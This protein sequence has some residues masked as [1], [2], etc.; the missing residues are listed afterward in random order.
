MGRPGKYFNRALVDPMKQPTQTQRLCAHVEWTNHANGHGVWKKC[1]ECKLRLEY[2][3]K[4]SGVVARYANFSGVCTVMNT[5]GHS[6]RAQK[7]VDDE[8]HVLII[9]DSGCKRSV[10]GPAWHAAMESACAKAGLKPI[11]KHIN[12]TFLFGD[13]D[14]V[15]AT[16]AVEYPVGIYELH[17]SLDVALVDRPCPGLMS[18]KAMGEL[19]CVMD[20]EQDTLK[21]KAHDGLKTMPINNSATGHPVVRLTD[22]GPGVHEAFPRKF[23]QKKATATSGKKK[24]TATS[25]KEIAEVNLSPKAE[26]DG[27]S[28]TRSVV[29]KQEP[30][31]FAD[32]KRLAR[33]ARKRL[34]R[35][36][37]QLSEAFRS[38]AYASRPISSH[39][40]P[41]FLEI[42][43]WTAMLSMVAMA[44]GWDVW[45]P[46]S[47]ETGF[48]LSTRDGQGKCWTY[49]EEIQPD[50]VAF[51]FPCDPWTQMQNVNQRTEEQRDDL[52][53]RRIKHRNIT[54][55]VRKVAKWQHE[56][57]AIFYTEQPATAL[58]L[59]LPEIRDVAEL[60]NTG[61]TDMC[62]YQLRCPETKAHLRKR[63]WLCSNSSGVMRKACT[64][65]DTQHS[66]KTI[67][68]S[69]RLPSGRRVRL[70]AFAG[71]YTRPFSEA[72]IT[73]MEMDLPTSLR[74]GPWRAGEEKEA[75]PASIKRKDTDMDAEERAV[76]TPLWQRRQMQKVDAPTRKRR[77][78]FNEAPERESNDVPSAPRRRLRRKTPTIPPRSEAVRQ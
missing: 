44:R 70:S 16:T 64:K 56:R 45:Q 49:L 66:H 26:T 27:E 13:G 25:K 3:D 35:V 5:S 72:V 34:A 73:G 47:L 60:C 7:E 75:Y 9:L 68:G 15:Q 31:V 21:V 1:K 71:G 59:K 57:G 8:G 2:C 38:E 46:A 28:E 62:M 42:C 39:R 18:R 33:G 24:A 14:E 36:T 20:F 22:F 23:Y 78:G 48:D 65:C 40:R 29:G 53:K 50:A 74:R 43:T 77:V 55:F 11:Y 30:G 51:A 63:T 10:A 19:G 6:K 37:T 52:Q 67:E 54:R 76:L 41:R 4:K 17:G 58:S 61:I 12:E 32:V 69:V